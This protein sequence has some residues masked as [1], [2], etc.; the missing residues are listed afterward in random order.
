MHNFSLAAERNKQPMVD[1][2]SKWLRGH[3][4]ILEVGSASGQHG[5]FFSQ[6][7]PH[8]H[9]QCSDRSDY[10]PELADNIK[11]ANLS[12]VPEPIKL[13]VMNYDWSLCQYNVVFTA[14]T[15]HIMTAAEVDYFLSQVHLALRPQGKLLVY[16][17]F[18]YQNDYTSVS[19]REFDVMLRERN[20]GSC[21]KS[22][23]VINEQLGNSQFALIDDISMPAN[24]RM[25][26]W[27]LQASV[28]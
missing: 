13:D 24:N 20:V 28:L 15:L 4:T 1:Q 6:Q 9:W 8:I 12:N 27:Q 19:N 7:M 22:F 21:I 2:L 10:L 14:N 17:P 5:L 23:E 18:N 16:G 26:A 25:I 11:T 3:E